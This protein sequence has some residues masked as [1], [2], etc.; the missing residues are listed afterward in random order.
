MTSKSYV[1]RPDPNVR[2]CGVYSK[3]MIMKKQSV[4]IAMALTMFFVNC[5]GA[6]GLPGTVDAILLPMNPTSA[7]NLKIS[8]QR[9]CSG[10]LPY[11]ADAYR[12]T[13]AQNKI[14]VTLGEVQNG[15][16][17]SACPPAPRE[18]VDLGRLPTGN[19]T[20]TVIKQA[21]GTTPGGAVVENAPFTVT[22]AR[23]VKI[24]PYVRLDYS[25]HWWDPN[26]SGWGL[27]I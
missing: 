7:D 19:Y 25:G 22:D 1:A 18:E 20:I 6:V 27:F 24:A 4:R 17:P 23:I 16:V 10:V 21:L 15:I 8:M 9:S 13:M 26:D 3:E 2:E 14:T 11:K 5:A 12:L